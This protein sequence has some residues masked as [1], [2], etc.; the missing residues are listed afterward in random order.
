V[1]SGED[2]AIRS[3]AIP[4][5]RPER[6]RE[7]AP[8]SEN[9]RASVPIYRFIGRRIYRDSRP[10]G[11]NAIGSKVPSSHHRCVPLIRVRRA[12]PRVPRTGRRLVRVSARTPFSPGRPR[13][14]IAHIRGNHR[15]L[16]ARARTSLSTRGS[17]SA[18]LPMPCGGACTGMQAARRAPRVAVLHS[19]QLIALHPALLARGDVLSGERSHMHET[20]R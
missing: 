12:L 19:E 15:V 1:I 4:F 3:Q 5:G 16:S 18:T 17:G 20:R 8:A 10:V 6:A 11:G 7:Q 9:R 2:A 13:A 14:T